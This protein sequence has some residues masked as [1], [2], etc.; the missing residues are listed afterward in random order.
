MT[1]E[2]SFSS[3]SA[4]SSTVIRE[5]EGGVLRSALVERL[6]DAEVERRERL[7]RTNF[8]IPSNSHIGRRPPPG[9]ND[10]AKWVVFNATAR[11]SSGQSVQQEEG[12]ILKRLM[13]F[14]A[15][16]AE[17]GGKIFKKRQPAEIPS[18]VPLHYDKMEENPKEGYH[19]EWGRKV[20]E[21]KKRR[22]KRELALMKA[23]FL[24]DKE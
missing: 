17:M 23:E 13:N 8:A 20:A 4:S 10:E 1:S 5:E 19:E 3:S 22:K 14:P 6:Y 11:A 15:E 24:P 21:E 18:S 12:D 2:S 16:D 7:R 9:Y